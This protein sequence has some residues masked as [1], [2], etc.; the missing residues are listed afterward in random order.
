MFVIN[1]F[2][3]CIICTSNQERPELKLVSHGRKVTLIGRHDVSLGIFR[4]MVNVGM[5]SPDVDA[6]SGV[7]VSCRH[8]GALASGKEIHGYGLKIMCGYVFACW[9][10]YCVAGECDLLVVIWFFVL[11]P[12]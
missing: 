5:V 6:L 7:L 3:N 10:F 2:Y 4:Q 9:C 1:F 12:L 11:C 8:L